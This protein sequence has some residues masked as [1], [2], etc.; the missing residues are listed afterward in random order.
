MPATWEGSAE[1]AAPYWGDLKGLG[2]QD[3]VGRER[4]W[5]N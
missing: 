1:T 4:S 5:G 3:I 2:S